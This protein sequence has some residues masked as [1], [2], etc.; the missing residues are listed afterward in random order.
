MEGPL[1]K[2]QADWLGIGKADWGAPGL[3]EEAVERTAVRTGMVG[4]LAKADQIV[5]QTGTAEQLEEVGQTVEQTERVAGK[6]K[7]GWS[8]PIGS[9]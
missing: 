3:T 2:L 5:G 6:S 8:E 1:Q 7:V 4:Q 9:Q